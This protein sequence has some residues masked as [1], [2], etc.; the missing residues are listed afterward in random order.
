MS[1][2]RSRRL[3]IESLESRRLLAAVDIPDDLTGAGSAIVSVPVNIDDAAAVR[4]AEI[5]LT[6][7]TALLDLDPN[8]ITA[9]SVWNGND[10]QVTANVNDAAGTV[11]IFVSASAGLPTSSG[12]LVV[13][14]FRIAGTATTGNTA[15][16]DLTEVTLNE[17]QINVSP[18]PVAGADSTDGLITVT[19]DNGNTGS[20]RIAGFVYA[21]TNN[22]STPEIVEG[23]PGVAITLTN[24]STDQVQTATT[25]DQ[26][27]YEFTGLSAGTYRVVQAQP[28]AY[29]EGG[30]NELSVNLVDGQASSNQ[31]FRELGLRPQFLSNRLHTTLVRPVGSTPWVNAIRQTNLDANAPRIAS[32]SAPV[33]ATAN[34]TV[35]SAFVAS[36]S[37]VEPTWRQATTVPTTQAMIQPAGEPIAEQASPKSFVVGPLAEQDDDSESD[38][39]FSVDQ[40]FAAQ[41]W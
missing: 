9:G 19:S 23:I 27:R 28:V 8:A 29:L 2:K 37:T 6:Y 11:V 31:N 38:E 30:V 32:V 7:D 25:D 21:D 16:I 22:N 26:G 4:G 24:T 5:R 15:V 39:T 35:A 17:G 34:A 10:T 20:D 3:S 18:T 14:P 33:P 41:L 36:P 40:V 1:K 12:S 13:L